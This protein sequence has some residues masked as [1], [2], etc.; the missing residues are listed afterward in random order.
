MPRKTFSPALSPSPGNSDRRPSRVALSRLVNG[1]CSE[2][3]SNESGSLGPYS[4]H[5]DQGQNSL[6]EFGL[7]LFVSLHPSRIDYLT[8]LLAYCVAYA[9]YGLQ[10][11]PVL[12]GLFQGEG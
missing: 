8:Y 12:H 9:G 1:R 6:G 3:L 7:E 10:I 5:L 2:L 4:W 11:H